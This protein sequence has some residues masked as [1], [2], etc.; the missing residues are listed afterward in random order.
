MS[1]LWYREPA[2]VF[3]WEEAL[4]LGNGRLGAMVFGIPGQEKIQ[5]NEESM[6]YGAARN[7]MNP[8]AL[9]HL[10]QIRQCIFNG[11]ISR[12]Q[13]LLNMAV[14]ACPDSM[15]PYQTLGNI[16]LEFDRFV[17]TEEYERSLDLD[18]A[19][20][21]VDYRQ[22]GVRLHREAF[23]SHPDDCL[24]LRLTADR[25]GS[26]TFGA[27]LERGRF[28]DGVE[29]LGQTGIAM[30][31]TLGQGGTS[32][33][34]GLRA[35]A[36]GGTVQVIGQTL[37]VEGADAVTLLFGADTSYQHRNEAQPN[38]WHAFLREQVEQTLNRAQTRGYDALLARHLADYQALYGRAALRLDGSEA[39]DALPTNQRLQQAK[40]GQ[41]DL[42]LSQ[43]LFDF[44]RYLL[45]SCSRPGG[46]PANLQGI[47]NQEFQ[48]P[49]ESKYT[50]NIN[51]QMN[52][53]PAES[54]NLSECH[55]PLFT[56]L[57][58]MV[59]SGR[60][61]ARGMYGCRGMVAHHNTDIHG[62]CA[63]QDTWLG[64]T[65]WV[66]GAAWLCT[67]VWTH[68]EYTLDKAF[69]RRFYPIMCESALFFLDFLVEKDGYLVTCPSLSPENE[70]RLPNGEQGAVTYGAT[71]DN[72]ILRDLFGQCLKAA[73]I[74]RG[75]P[76]DA[77]ALAQDLAGRGIASETEFLTQVRQACARLIPN[78][79]GSD[80]RIMEWV[81]EY[82]ECDMGHRHISHLYGLH[83]SDQITMDG[84]PELA[85]AARKTLESRLSHG[86]GHTGWSRA[87]IINHYAK[88]WDGE[89]A[90]EN[91]QQLLAVSTYANLFD[92]HP[93]FQIDG[94]FGAAA[95]IAEMLVQSTQERVVLLPALPQAWPGGSVRGLRLRG[96]AEVSVEWKDHALLRCT[97]RA[98]HAWTH[99]V[100]YAGRECTVSL[101]PGES[102]SL[103]AE[104]FT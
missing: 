83:P 48:P 90:H 61:M 77:D 86:G 78:R 31:G 51:A 81:E 67:H 55:L 79:I 59:K 95:A 93:P 104:S 43:L 37:Y 4:P 24:V 9:S 58:Q 1:K 88:L 87:W 14:A 23:I 44:G 54:C 25:P 94:N 11:E 80:G 26:I 39:F 46:L 57:E 36:E 32:F 74:L 8:D 102:V 21:T 56:L 29:K 18:R 53:W 49:W 3:R 45:I 85:A 99:R 10:E 62:D 52:Y 33:V 16:Q 92:R 98:G 96:D 20:C 15:Q 50:I 84:T 76:A 27:R 91:L 35:C 72:Q 5:V 69:L 64:S 103:S 12:A 100:V 75:E 65:Y 22:N 34:S 101:Q 41:A 73:E 66:M 71:M 89:K 97:I 68:Y 7:R 17:Q 19:V 70:Y 28:F 2:A 13:T 38:D 42:G 40:E 60:Q 82:E 30:Y 6:W 47:W 63:P